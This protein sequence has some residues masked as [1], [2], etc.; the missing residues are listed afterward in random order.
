MSFRRFLLIGAAVVSIGGVTG[1]MLR[2]RPPL[3][4]ETSHDFGL[5]SVPP[6]FPVELRH[7]FV[8]TNRRNHPIKIVAARPTCG[9]T[10]MLRTEF[11]RTVEPGAVFELPVLF[12]FHSVKK[13]VTIEL[14]LETDGVQSLR[15]SATGR[16]ESRL[17]ASSYDLA[18]DDKGHGELN[19]V[20]NIYGT[21][22]MPAPPTVK[23]P[24]GVRAAFIGWALRWAPKD[25]ADVPCQWDGRVEIEMDDPSAELADDAALTIELTPAPPISVKIARSAPRS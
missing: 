9:C 12:N 8:L 14:V 17:Y 21:D 5:V 13:E 10:T 3:A 18:L 1:W 23:A 16:F 11:P 15:I 20:A 19:L 6:E 4:G 2:P 7:T 25:P 22:A 24:Q